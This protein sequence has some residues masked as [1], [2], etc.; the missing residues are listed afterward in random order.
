MDGISEAASLVTL[1]QLAAIIINHVRSIVNAPV[2][3]RKL[4][5]ALI[6]A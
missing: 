4:L 5:A 6:Q 3:K 1:V 2:Q